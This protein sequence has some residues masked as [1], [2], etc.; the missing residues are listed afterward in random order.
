MFNYF[1]YRKIAGDEYVFEP[2]AKEIMDVIVPQLLR[3]Q[4]H[5]VVLES[6]AS[7]HSSRMVAMKS[8]SDNAQDLIG[9]LSIAYNKARQSSIT[10]E[11]TEITAGREALESA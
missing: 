2:S 3:I 4:I 8:A 6:N 5:H 9:S 11:L 1:R 7:E 10:Q